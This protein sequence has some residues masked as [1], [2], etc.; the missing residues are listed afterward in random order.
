MSDLSTYRIEKWNQP[1]VRDLLCDLE[2]SDVLIPD[3]RLQTIAD[4]WNE[5]TGGEYEW[6]RGRVREEMPELAALLDALTEENK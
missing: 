4:A 3:D 2:L 1:E 6:S 5:G